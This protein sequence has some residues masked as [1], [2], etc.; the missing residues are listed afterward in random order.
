MNEEA[1]AHWWGG[2]LHQKN[3]QIHNGVTFEVQ[4]CVVDMTSSKYILKWISHFYGVKRNSIESSNVVASWRVPNPSIPKNTFT[5]RLVYFLLHT[6]V[7]R[8]ASDINKKREYVRNIV[9]RTA[10]KEHRRQYRGR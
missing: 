8:I 6:C 4:Y 10:A 5:L 3:K 9:G 7:I 2:L 1:L